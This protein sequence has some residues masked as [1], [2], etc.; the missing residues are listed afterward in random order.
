[1]PQDRPS[2]TAREADGLR[3]LT[4]ES[5][6]R[7]AGIRIAL[8]TRDGGR[9][10][11]PYEALNLAAHVG[12]D[13]V[14]VDANRAL[15]LNALEIEPLRSRLTTAEQVHGLTLR[16][17]SGA[18]VGM[19]AFASPAGP[20]AVP[21]TDALYTLEAGVP[22]LLLYAD[23]VPVVLV[24]P[25]P[26]RGIAVVHAGWKGALGRLPGKAAVTLAAATGCSTSDLLVYIGP[27]IGPCHYEVDSERLSHFVGAF[28]S[29]AS[30]QGRLDL[31]AVVYE[32]M[33]EVGVSPGNMV[34]AGV[35]TAEET[36]S[37]YSFR[38]EGRTGRHGALAV[39]L[40]SD[41]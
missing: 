6:G 35:C 40:E 41:R 7:S 17:V 36:D 39:I 28:G 19:G 22:L 23:C 20:P 30:A 16:E 8:T 25:E 33:S 10:V 9:S 2:L 4:D 5:L 29:I 38:A 26:T 32:T 31:G 11:G 27:H 24:A 34:S 1:M 13:P 21:A 18:T 3:W 37:F 14:A 15:L 12:D